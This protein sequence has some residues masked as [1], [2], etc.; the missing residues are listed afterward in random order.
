MPRP[1][2]SAAADA[3]E[4]V[5]SR[6]FVYPAGRGAAPLR[7][8]TLA[9]PKTTFEEL[10]LHRVA[11]KTERRMEMVVGDLSPA[12]AK[13]QLSQRCGIERI[14]REPF[15]VDDRAGFLEPALRSLVLPNG[16]GP[17]QGDDWGRTDRHQRIV[18][19]H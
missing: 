4:S 14:G 11:G 18:E 9:G 1:E 2:P 16:D 7:R 3:E 5:S 8:C 13:F 17:I 12:G 6:V 15:A 19:R 10:P